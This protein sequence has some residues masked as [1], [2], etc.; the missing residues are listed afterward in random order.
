MKRGSCLPDGPV[1]FSLGVG[2][3]SREWS[4]ELTEPGTV[5]VETPY[6]RSDFP[7][8]LMDG[9]SYG[10]LVQVIQFCDQALSQL[11]Q[12]PS[13]TASKV[14]LWALLSD[15]KSSLRE[16]TLAG[17]AS[18]V[19]LKPSADDPAFEG[20]SS[21]RLEALHVLLEQLLKQ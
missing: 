14:Q 2:T 17:A 18:L 15:I 21:R 5:T 10:R 1:A 12:S 13:A 3:S 8:G 11:L 9:E 16:G 6:G 7:V 4:D 19:E 20:S